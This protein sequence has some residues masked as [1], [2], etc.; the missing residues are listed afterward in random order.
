MRWAT[1]WNRRHL[2]IQSLL[3]SALTKRIIWSNTPTFT[4][5]SKGIREMNM[6]NSRKTNLVLERC[7]WNSIF[8]STGRNPLYIVISFPRQ[9]KDILFIYVPPFF[10]TVYETKICGSLVTLN[11]L[12][13]CPS[14][15]LKIETA[16][17]HYF[18]ITC[19][20]PRLLSEH[21]LE[22]SWGLW[23]LR[24][25]LEISGTWLRIQWIW[26]IAVIITIWNAASKNIPSEG[27]KGIHEQEKP[28]NL[29]IVMLQS[30][31]WWLRLSVWGTFR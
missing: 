8:A 6:A 31:F 16:D 10:P 13:T 11:Y 17:D 5:K 25:K 18:I 2:N 27:N 20:E 14:L 28:S 21:L 22:K 19:L 1:E 7:Q 26:L 29:V 24:Q 9:P 12:V 4:S 23:K 15:S 3:T 30:R